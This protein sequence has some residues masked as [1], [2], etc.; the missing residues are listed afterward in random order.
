VRNDERIASHIR[1]PNRKFCIRRAERLRPEI[2]RG[3][4][5]RKDRRARNGRRRE[6]HFAAQKSRL[7]RSI[8]GVGEILRRRANRAVRIVMDADVEATIG[9][10]GDWKSGIDGA[11]ARLETTIIRSDSDGVATSVAKHQKGILKLT[12]S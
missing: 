5:E 2:E 4:R 8:E 11:P 12:N 3:V 6:R 10:K 7:P 1:Q 9:R